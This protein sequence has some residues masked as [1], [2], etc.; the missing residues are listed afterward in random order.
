MCCNE[1]TDYKMLAKLF[2][3]IFALLYGKDVRK[4][5][6]PI[7][8]GTGCAIFRPL[9]FGVVNFCPVHENNNLEFYCYI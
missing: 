6:T 5:V 3:D 2:P 4:D 9:S 8:W 7:L 1:S